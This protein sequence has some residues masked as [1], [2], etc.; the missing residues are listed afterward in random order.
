MPP[1]FEF[2]GKVHKKIQTNKR[3][4]TLTRCKANNKIQNKQKNIERVQNKT[5]I[6]LKM[7]L[8]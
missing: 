8:K 2:I 5:R 1:K 4:R 6:F 3:K 7:I